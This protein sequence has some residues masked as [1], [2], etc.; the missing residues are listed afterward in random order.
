MKKTRYIVYRDGNIVAYCNTHQE[1][2]NNI[3]VSRQYISHQLAKGNHILGYGK[4]YQLVNVVDEY[5]KM[6]E[7]GLF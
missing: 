1:I 2:S 5:W 3:F 6:K 7:E 4:A